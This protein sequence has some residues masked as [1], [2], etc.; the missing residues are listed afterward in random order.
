M[1]KQECHGQVS[2][3]KLSTGCDEVDTALRGM[4]FLKA[5][6]MALFILICVCVCVCAHA[7]AH[8]H[9]FSFLGTVF[10]PLYLYREEIF[11]EN[12]MACTYCRNGTIW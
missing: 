10:I 6:S 9:A 8:A 5:V 11:K 1:W 3:P 7:H 12:N 4:I 2:S